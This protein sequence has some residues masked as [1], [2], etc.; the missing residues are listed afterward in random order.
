MLAFAISCSADRP[1]FL[2]PWQAEMLCR[3]DAGRS[4]QTLV[5]KHDSS[6]NPQA[7][8]FAEPAGR[9]TLIWTFDLES[10][11]LSSVRIQDLGHVSDLAFSVC[12]GASDGLYASV[13]S[14]YFGRNSSGIVRI[15]IDAGSW[16]T[17]M[18]SRDELSTLAIERVLRDGSLESG[19]IF[20]GMRANI[21]MGCCNLDG[22]EARTMHKVGSNPRGLVFDIPRANGVTD[23]L[24]YICGNHTPS[25]VLR[26]YR[27][28]GG[29]CRD[30]M[31]GGTQYAVDADILRNA[32][33]TGSDVLLLTG[34][35]LLQIYGGQWQVQFSSAKV[36]AGGL[37]HAGGLA[38]DRLGNIYVL[39][40]GRGLLWKMSKP[41]I[42]GK[43]N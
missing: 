21:H 33:G 26:P 9:D 42:D 3:W 15:D 37:F 6:G 41:G 25:V 20:Y 27:V 4:A 1:A 32:D 30:A 11:R 18:R 36:L 2:P 19:R 13:I 17:V 16:Q 12:A 23:G 40:C 28:N 39:E 43:K 29:S 7:L 8:L 31:V 14:D 34:S 24:F 22:S 5:L 10:R 38:S 35:K